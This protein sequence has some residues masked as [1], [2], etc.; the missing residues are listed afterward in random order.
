[1]HNALSF[2]LRQI[3]SA[4]ESKHVITKTWG[5]KFDITLECGHELKLEKARMPKKGKVRCFACPPIGSHYDPTVK[6]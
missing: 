6:Q 5:S 2:P 1:M 3:S 4:I